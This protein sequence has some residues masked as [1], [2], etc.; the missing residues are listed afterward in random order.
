VAAIAFL[1]CYAAVQLFHPPLLWYLPLERRFSFG[2]RPA[3]ISM[4]WYG[5]TLLASL[6]ALISGGVAALIRRFVP[7]TP[8]APPWLYALALAVSLGLALFIYGA[9]PGD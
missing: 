5:R 6:V 8:G 1:L 9:R 4:D 7:R 2:E 3:E